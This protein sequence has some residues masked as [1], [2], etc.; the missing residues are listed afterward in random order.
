MTSKGGDRLVGCE[1][2]Q[3][4]LRAALADAFQDRG[5]VVLIEG[6]AGIGKTALA[7]DLLAD[8]Q[9]RGALMLVGR[10]YA[11]S[12]TPPYGPG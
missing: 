1:Y 12:D 3:S 4:L 6:E 8:A 2:E 7:E 5:S 11:L 10:C 9:G